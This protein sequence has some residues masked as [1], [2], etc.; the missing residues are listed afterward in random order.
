M[1]LINLIFGKREEY[2]IDCKIN[3]NERPVIRKCRCGE[4]LRGSTKKMSAD[5]M[6]L[7]KGKLLC[8]KCAWEHFEYLYRVSDIF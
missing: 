2:P 1:P 8:Q 6:Y 4:P 3:V 5:A 7:V